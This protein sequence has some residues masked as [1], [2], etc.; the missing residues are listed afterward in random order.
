MLQHYLEQ[1]ILEQ[2]LKIKI[3]PAKASIYSKDKKNPFADNPYIQKGFGRENSEQKPEY[4]AGD[5][6]SHF[7]FGVGR[8]TSL[9]KLDHDYE[10][11]VEFE[12][13]GQRKLRTSFAKLQ[14]L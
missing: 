14:K 13:F 4:K 7:K 3:P 9:T 8:V 2:N 10:V 11:V 1:K 5:S 12:G 6:V